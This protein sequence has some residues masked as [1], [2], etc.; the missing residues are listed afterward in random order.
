MIRNPINKSHIEGKLYQHKLSLKVSGP[1]SKNPGVEFISGEIE[2]AT[3]EAGLNIIPVHF[4]YVTALTGK[5]ASNGTFA[6]LSKIISGEYQTIMEHGA[7]KAT[8]LRVDSAIGL[9]EF[10]SSRSGQEELVSVKRNEGGFVHVTTTLEPEEEKRNSFE[11][12]M[13][14]TK[15]TRIE[16]DPEKST[17]DKVILKGA[18]FDYRGNLLP[19]E[20]SVYDE[21]GMNYFE[22]LEISSKSPA[23]TRLEGNQISESIVRRVEEETAFGS[24][25][26]KEYKSVRK[27]FVIARAKR[28]TY[29]WDEETTKWLTDK[30]AD[31]QLALAELKRKNEEWK[32]QQ[33]APTPAPASGKFDF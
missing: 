8:S 16:G 24:P 10:Y 13:V 27:D 15:V 19:V 25:S 20:F 23:F 14:V 1:K 7:D 22:G 6:V 21:K 11:C 9:N 3:D 26:I 18:I 30:M 5:G 2:I 33:N 4:T 12:D 32:A 28:D 31:R 17:E 29:E